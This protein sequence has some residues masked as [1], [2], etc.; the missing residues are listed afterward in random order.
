MHF[1]LNDIRSALQRSPAPH[2]KEREAAVLL[3]LIEKKG[4]L[5]IL[6]ERRAQRG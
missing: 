5:F 2:K 6:F 1:R 3:P 4:E